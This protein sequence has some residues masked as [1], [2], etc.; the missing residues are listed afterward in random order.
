MTTLYRLQCKDCPEWFAYS[1][2]AARQDRLLGRTPPE[3]CPACRQKHRREYQ[4]LGMSHYD[5]LQL[6]TDGVGGLAHFRRP[7]A[8]PKTLETRRLA[9]DPFPIEAIIGAPDR[10]G[11]LLHGLLRD[12]RRVHLVVGP[13]GSGKSTWL[14]FRLLTCAELVARGPI[15]ITQPRIPA[16]EGPAKFVGKLYYGEG[17]EPA[18]GPGLAV[19]YRYS[20]IGDTMR[21]SANRL[22]FTTDGTLLGW[23][24]SG[25]IRRYSV[26]MIDEAHERSVNIDKILALLRLKLPEWPHLQVI[27]A[28]ATVDSEVFL[29][30]FGGSE[31]VAVYQSRGFT[32]PILEVFADESLVHCPD[33]IWTKACQPAGGVISYG[34]SEIVR[35][36]WTKA[37]QPAAE[38]ANSVWRE[39]SEDTRTRHLLGPPCWHHSGFPDYRLRYYRQFEALI[40]QGPMSNDEQRLL[41]IGDEAWQAVVAALADAGRRERRIGNEACAP[42]TESIRGKHKQAEPGQPVRVDANTRNRLI[43]ASVDTV[44]SLIER[45]RAEAGHRLTRWERRAA[46]GWPD[47]HRPLPV[48]HILIF[49]PTSIDIEQC[50]E[51]IEGELEQRGWRE[52]NRVLRFYKDAPVEEKRQATA[53][54][55][56]DERL[57]RIVVGS[58][59]AETSLTL[60]GLTY[61]VDSGLICEEYFD[62]EQGKQLPT[63][64]HS[65]A[66]CRQRVGR[67]GRKEPGEAYRLYTRDELLQQAPFTTPQI[68]RCNA[69][70]V[71]LDLIRAGLPPDPSALNRGLINPPIRSELDRAFAVLRHYQAVDE[72]GDVT[73]RG[74]ELATIEG[75]SFLDAQLRCEA[76]RFGVLWE[77]AVF[78]AFLQLGDT[79]APLRKIG[80]TKRRPSRWKWLALWDP[81]ARAIPDDAEE[82]A[83]SDTV[84]S[85]WRN[86]YV[87]GDVL[88]K[89]QHLLQDCLDDLELYLRIWQGWHAQ[90]APEARRRWAHRHGV[91][92]AALVKVESLLGLG[93]KDEKGLLHRFWDMRR[94]GVMQRDVDFTRLD[95]V[96]F[97]Y[98]AASPE[99]IFERVNTNQ[100]SQYRGPAEQPLAFLHGESVWNAADA[101]LQR[102]GREI[103]RR[104]CVAAIKPKGRIR[105]LRHVVWLDPDWLQSEQPPSFTESPLALARRFAAH[106]DQARAWSGEQPF[107]SAEA[108][109]GL[110]AKMP[111]IRIPKPDRID[112]WW[113]RYRQ[114]IDTGSK[115]SAELSNIISAPQVCS[116]TPVFVRLSPECEIPLDEASAAL[117]A[118]Q[119]A[120]GRTVQ[121]RLLID[122][123]LLYG[124]L[125]A[126]REQRAEVVPLH[127]QNR[128]ARPASLPPVDLVVTAEVVAVVCG[129]RLHGFT[130]RI[131]SPEHTG[132]EIGID[133]RLPESTLHREAAKGRRLQ[134]KIKSLGKQHA[135]GRLQR[136]CDGGAI[137][138][139][140]E[141]WPVGTVLDAVVRG[142]HPKHDF[143]IQVDVPLSEH[144][145]F[146][147][148]AKLGKEQPGNA[149]EGRRLQIRVERWNP[150]SPWPHLKWLRWLD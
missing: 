40:L 24:Q 123:G 34:F 145:R 62:P 90:S 25:E 50:V 116:Q 111:A 137:R 55:A 150:G 94:K 63:I 33:E 122:R 140:A 110:P 100:F 13:T 61:V 56:P 80:T 23:L 41:Q 98:A 54:C 49:L 147:W 27:I 60:H 112:Q 108:K 31:Q 130:A 102:F 82:D 73:H 7:R 72:D 14:P 85:P 17:V 89:R 3:R 84:R 71:V 48:G 143:L 44:L 136:W 59:L 53:E 119:F 5:V 138:T 43:H 127:S 51:L 93:P 38:S 20:E 117:A 26:V 125:D 97:L 148:C 141:D 115:Q 18:V 57:R 1:E 83:P 52:D 75:Q 68:A 15:V 142:V 4:S 16:T 146:R 30:Y 64:L 46:Y 65:Q 96:R 134:A 8:E 128:T 129:K 29:N 114:A 88:L 131:V 21:D 42:I 124:S 39:V 36:L 118:E 35:E 32:Y 105:E 106:A 133:S 6:R 77:M 135:F 149:R 126:A 28:S 79:A 113:Q 45:D 10:A 121:V 95:T 11:S 91:S 76:D 70:T 9:I 101:R 87:L 92:H 81:T 86:P 109:A 22:L 78:L 120:P 144:H 132:C 2:E 67:V 69:E 107:Q 104:F 99:R 66:G 58:N 47:L 74:E 139:L 37:F 103:E 12:Q 19:G